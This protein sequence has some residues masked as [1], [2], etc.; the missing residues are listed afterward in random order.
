M[1]SL[2]ST[3]GLHWLDDEGAVEYTLYRRDY[4]DGQWGAPLATY[5]A[6]TT[7]WTDSDVQINHL[8]EYRIIKTNSDFDSLGYGYILSGIELAPVHHPGDLLILAT[9]NTH[10]QISEEIDNY[11]SIL[12]A[13]GWMSRQLIVPANY[14]A[15]EVKEAIIE[16]FGNTPF[17]AILIL[18][19]VPVPHSGNINPDAHNDHRGAW[20]ADLYYGDLDGTW[21]DQIVTNTSSD[22][23]RNHNIPGDG[24]FDQSVIPSDIDV[25]VG[26]VDFSE[27]PTFADDEYELLRK[28]LIKDIAYRT[29]EISVNRRAMIYNRNLWNGGLGQNGMRF[30]PIVGLDQLNYDNWFQVVVEPFQW[31]YSGSAGSYTASF[32]MGDTE[33][34]AN[35]S[36]QSVFT[37]WFGSYFGDYDYPDA[38][39]R[40]HLGSGT[41]L[42][43]VWAGAPH[44]YF[45]PMGMGFPLATATLSTQ[46]ND[47]IYHAGFFPRS[48]HV[49]LLGDP[50]LGAYPFLGPEY[51]AATSTN[52]CVELE[53]ASSSDTVLG[54]YLYRRS[55]PDS[56][57]K[58]IAELDASTLS[59]TDDCL[60]ALG[61]YEYLV[62][63]YRLEETPSG[64][65][66]N[67]SSG[68][69]D[70]IYLP[71][72]YFPTSQ[73]EVLNQT[74]DQ[75]TL[76]STATN[77][78]SLI[79]ILP[80]GEIRHEQDISFMLQ[81][82]ENIVSL[83]A[84]NRCGQD[85]S[86]QQFTLSSNTSLGQKD[87]I[88]FP[89][90]ANQTISVDSSIPIRSI[91]LLQINGQVIN[92]YPAFDQKQV[93]IDIQDII[94]GQYLLTIE[95]G[96]GD[97][98]VKKI[99]IVK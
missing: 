66:Y 47:S 25:A 5:P 84:I 77:A 21:T 30:S 52:G 73:F 42:S 89:N 18:G 72:D 63:A 86:A 37:A 49:N 9:D 23:D 15:V 99:S 10:N 98:I 95:T 17:S 14:S 46:N 2:T 71:T 31:F 39:M 22:N 82:G 41:V 81:E 65:F 62:R 88:M 59:Y 48:I 20:S 96:P 38:F 19:D 87:L 94:A 12:T 51:L 56:L 36:F 78:D 40:S 45:H 1:N 50:T 7:E 55:D 3:I 60:E 70:Q 32:L 6:G 27:L 34:Y 28:Y 93:D 74:E 90:P 67:L 91:C 4:P 83:I 85:T 76:S 29:G 57:F 69:V 64:S 79:W 80:S 16:T 44:W 61:T 8:Y 68:K 58:I 75:L 54:Y 53:W 13:E 24:R 35:N 43:S 26:R 11:Q 92:V 97:I 33:F